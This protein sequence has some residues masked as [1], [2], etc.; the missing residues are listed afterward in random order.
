MHDEWRPTRSQ[1]SQGDALLK[2]REPGPVTLRACP[3]LISDEGR[4]ADHDIVPGFGVDQEE[5]TDHNRC[6]SACRVDDLA[7]RIGCGSMNLH[8]VHSRT[9]CAEHGQ[10]LD[11]RGQECCLASG[12]LEYGVCGLTDR[13]C[14]QV[15]GDRGVCVERAASLACGGWIMTECCVRRVTGHEIRL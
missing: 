3:I 13:P 11:C 12:R 10:P 9:V 5:V 7:R 2:S 1:S 15:L 4:V 8:A 6:D 14:R